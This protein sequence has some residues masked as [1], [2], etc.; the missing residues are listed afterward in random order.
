VFSPRRSYLALFG[1]L[2]L[3]PIH[4]FA[5]TIYGIT[6]DDNLLKITVGPSS[7][8]ASLIGQLDTVPSGGSSS[9]GIGML[10]G[11]LYV[12][13]QNNQVLLQIS[14]TDA[15]TIA[16]INL[17]ISNTGE[18]DLAFA[19]DGTGYLVSTVHSDG[20]FD[21]TTGA[22]YSFATTPSSAKLITD[23]LGALIDGLT[24][25]TS[26]NGLA[27][28]Q[29]GATLDSISITGAISPI[30]GTG[31]D[32]T[33]GAFTC[34]S[35]GGLTFSGTTLY[36]ALGSFSSPTS[37]FYTIDPST[38]AA[39]FLGSIPFGEVSGI[40]GAASSGP[41]TVPEPSTY[42]LMAS[43]ALAIMVR[44]RGRLF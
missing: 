36:G 11:N 22:M 35:L 21:G 6:L 26:G 44:R 32:T 42:V 39:T 1:A 23:S 10:G 37:N 14:A 30:G 9:L 34:Y 31:I 38:G 40:T 24:F 13:D 18:G 4:N 33:C 29:G 43:A 16:T 8:S 41:A 28:E 5:S 17:G 20:S 25:D 19:P 2:A 27:L 3:F 7:V 15:H 12:Y